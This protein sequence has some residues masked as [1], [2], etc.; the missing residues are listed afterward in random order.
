M[1]LLGFTLLLKGADWLVDGSCSIAKRAGISQLII[2]LTLV[3]FGTSL[4]EFFINIASRIGGEADITIGDVLGSNIANILLVLGLAA[5]IR[6]LVFKK[7]TMILEIPFAFAVAVVLA[8]LLNDQDAGT[9][10]FRGLTRLD[11]LILLALFVMFIFYTARINK[12]GA[13][14]EIEPLTHPHSPGRSTL[15]VLAGIP[16]LAFGA[17][18]TVGG[19]TAV[20]STLGISEAVIGL[21]VVALG[22][23]LPELATSLIASF[24]KR[25]DIA[26]GNVVGSNIFN[27]CWI[28]GMSSFVSP[29]PIPQTYFFDIGAI[30][31]VTLILLFSVIFGKPGVIGRWNGVIF[32]FLYTA[33]VVS[34]VFRSSGMGVVR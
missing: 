5:A 30:I 20:A 6:P 3:A 1:L 14:D 16:S 24:K 26:I 18:W 32:L 31:F 4:P 23:S 22:T 21:T 27:I 9:G 12:A 11:G 17:K 15:M 29:L 25:S 33:Y 2:G 28:L 8:L 34:L 19:A 10:S 13:I 7:S